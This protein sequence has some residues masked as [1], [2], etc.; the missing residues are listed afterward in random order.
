MYTL[1]WISISHFTAESYTGIYNLLASPLHFCIVSLYRCK[2]EL[3]RAC[4]GNLTRCCT[5][6]ETNEHPRSTQYNQ[7]CS[8]S[9]EGFFGEYGIFSQNVR[10]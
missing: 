3:S 5:S 7:L 4:T 10:K 9:D 2:I 1:D 6:P 8:W